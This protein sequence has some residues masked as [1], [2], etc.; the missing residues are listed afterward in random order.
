MWALVDLEDRIKVRYVDYQDHQL[1]APNNDYQRKPTLRM[2]SMMD[3]SDEEASFLTE[4]NAAIR[5]LSLPLDHK[6]RHFWQLKVLGIAGFLKRKGKTHTLRYSLTAFRLLMMYGTSLALSV[7]ARRRVSS[8]VNSEK[9]C[10]IFEKKD[11]ISFCN[12]LNFWF[13]VGALLEMP[14]SN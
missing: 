11:R 10:V 14:S 8:S 4:R 2:I 3:S 5:I 7:M 1:F 13:C 9:I 12:V 6:L